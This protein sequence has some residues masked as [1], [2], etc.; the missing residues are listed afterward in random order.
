MVCSTT[1]KLFYCSIAIICISSIFL[2]SNTTSL[3]EK[4]I[5]KAKET[6]QKFSPE[7]KERLFRA[8]KTIKQKLEQAKTFAKKH[9]KAT[10]AASVVGSVGAT[11]AI[12]GTGTVATVVGRKVG[13]RP[14][15]TIFKKAKSMGK[16]FTTESSE[17]STRAF[18]TAFF[19][20]PSEVRD[21]ALEKILKSTKGTLEEQKQQT[22]AATKTAIETFFGLP[23]EQ[24]DPGLQQ[25]LESMQG[26]PEE[27]KEQIINATKTVIE[28]AASIPYNQKIEI[29]RAGIEGTFKAIPV[30]LI[31]KTITAETQKGVESVTN[32]AKDVTEIVKD[33]IGQ[34]I[35]V[36]G[37]TQEETQEAYITTFGQS[38]EDYEKAEKEYREEQALELIPELF[39]IKPKE[40]KKIVTKKIGKQITL[41]IKK[42]PLHKEV[43][44]NLNEKKLTKDYNP[45]NRHFKLKNANGSFVATKNG[46]N[47]DT[48]E[49]KEATIFTSKSLLEQATSWF[50]SFLSP[51]ATPEEEEFTIIRNPLYPIEFDINLHEKGYR[52][53]M[54]KEFPKQFYLKTKSNNYIATGEGKIFE[55]VSDRDDATIFEEKEFFDPVGPPENLE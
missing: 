32:V 19:N 46:A 43:Y 55:K 25:I 53:H 13:V 15:K 29:V 3:R 31:K 30:E 20:L 38:V 42:T 51:I 28:A 52:K 27:S 37:E 41:T 33:P 5:G 10:T 16:Y 50:S 35:G 44:I 22:I 12:V 34:T 23:P 6:Y 45:N 4:A 17:A 2:H 47:F 21:P 11:A 1:K 54:L 48:V 8:K 14:E 18:V 49:E 40:K 39:E 26:T 24:R 9:P 7:I 36:P